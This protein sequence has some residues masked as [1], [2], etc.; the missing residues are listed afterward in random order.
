VLFVVDHKISGVASLTAPTD[1]S[2]DMT[3]PA[4]ITMDPAGI[5]LFAAILHL[6]W[7]VKHAPS[8]L[9]VTTYLE[10]YLSARVSI[11]LDKDG[12]YWI[13]HRDRKAPVV[14]RIDKEKPVA[15]CVEVQTPSGVFARVDL[16]RIKLAP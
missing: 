7:G 15:E 1:G 14:V 12:V 10:A 13:T 2:H 11:S 9:S 6:V 8:H 16:D 3:M 5:D 4:S